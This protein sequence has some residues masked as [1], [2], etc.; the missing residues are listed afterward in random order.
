MKS[1][2]RVDRNGTITYKNLH[3]NLHREDGPAYEEPNA[4]KKWF[5]RG[6]LHREDGPAVE[7]SNGNVYYWLE[8]ILFTKGLWEEDVI[9][10]RLD[11]IKDL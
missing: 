1:Y 9:K 11:R 2:K 4:V 6:K 8:G 10:I 7:Y 3:G 5:I